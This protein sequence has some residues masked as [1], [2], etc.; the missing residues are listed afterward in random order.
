MIKVGQ[1]YL[2]REPDGRLTILSIDIDRVYYSFE[3]S[4]GARQGSIG[5]RT[6][7]R[8]IKDD[9][10]IFLPSPTLLTLRR[11]RD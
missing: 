9:I 11:T 7:E 10:W 5:L 6:M 8:Y 3:Q 2:Y 4:S 1:Q